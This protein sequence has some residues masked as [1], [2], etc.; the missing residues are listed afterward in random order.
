MTGYPG[1]TLSDD[2]LLRPVRS[3]PLAGR[4]VPKGQ[5]YITGAEGM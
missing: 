3:T 5:H 2:L 4:G 1:L